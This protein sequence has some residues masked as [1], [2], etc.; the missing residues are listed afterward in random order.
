VKADREG[1]QEREGEE[2]WPEAEEA[3][4]G[5]RGG[6]VGAGAGGEQRSRRGAGEEQGRTQA[7]EGR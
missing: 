6:G 1:Q 2:N 3:R 7:R 5:A 4:R